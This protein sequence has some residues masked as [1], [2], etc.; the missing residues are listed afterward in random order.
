MTYVLSAPVACCA[1]K[2]VEAARGRGKCG[3]AGVLLI[4]PAEAYLTV[5]WVGY[6]MALFHAWLEAS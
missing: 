2:Y 3:E 6:Q 4:A 1:V 5:F